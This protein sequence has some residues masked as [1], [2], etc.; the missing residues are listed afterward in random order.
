MKLI[1]SSGE[2]IIFLN[3]FLTRGQET[4]SFGGTYWLHLRNKDD[5]LK[6]WCSPTTLHMQS[7]TSHMITTP[8]FC[9]LKVSNLRAYIKILIMAAVELKLLWNIHLLSR[10]IWSHNMRCYPFILFYITCMYPSV[11]QL[12]AVSKLFEFFLKNSVLK[13]PARIVWQVR[14]LATLS[15]VKFLLLQAVSG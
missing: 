14:N 6:E 15:H 8:M 1:I 10:R 12:A 11:C 2:F 4:G 7:V 3:L 9:A 13:S 5:H